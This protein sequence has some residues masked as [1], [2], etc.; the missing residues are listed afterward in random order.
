[1]KPCP[2]SMHER[3]LLIEDELPMRTA[4]QDCLEA[5]GYRVLACA[6]G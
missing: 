6:D 4:L 3:L 1:M 2:T 5:E